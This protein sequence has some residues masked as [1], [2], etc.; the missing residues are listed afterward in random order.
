MLQ[1]GEAIFVSPVMENLAEEEYG[2]VLLLRRL[3]CKEVVGLVIK[4]QCATLG[5]YRRKMTNFGASRGRIRVPQACSSSR[6]VAAGPVFYQETYHIWRVVAYL[7]CIPHDGLAVL[8]N[9]AKLRE[10][11]GKRQ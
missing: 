9:E 6:T 11:R 10:V 1:Y 4:C 8:D 2:D 3:R 5:R 7:D